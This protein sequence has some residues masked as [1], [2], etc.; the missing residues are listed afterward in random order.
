MLNAVL[1]LS[2]HRY[3]SPYRIAIVY[4]G[5]KETEKAFQWLMKAYQDRSVWLI[6]L[7]LKVDPRLKTLH[8]DPRFQE[9]LRLMNFD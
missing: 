6:H 4:T 3:V 5:L 9:I 1:E 8:S 7:H 2:E